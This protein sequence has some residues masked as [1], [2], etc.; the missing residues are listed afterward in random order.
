MKQINL[1]NLSFLRS[2]IKSGLREHPDL[3]RKIDE[4]SRHFLFALDKILSAG[5][6][7]PEKFTLL[8]DLEAMDQSRDENKSY[9][10]NFNDILYLLKDKGELNVASFNIVYKKIQ[11][12]NPDDMLILVH[13]ISDFAKKELLNESTI[14]YLDVCTLPQFYNLSVVILDRLKDD[15]DTDAIKL[16]FTIDPEKLEAVCANKVTFR[17]NKGEVTYVNREQLKQFIK[18]YA[19]KHPLKLTSPPVSTAH[20]HGMSPSR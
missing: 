17:M 7:D 2:K 14:A 6:F 20:H 5:I 1:F 11:E 15:A 4:K 9:L 12:I 3:I 19:E 18:E 16:L 10:G 13:I 8:E